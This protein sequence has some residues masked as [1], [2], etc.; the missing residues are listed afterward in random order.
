MKGM[1]A[2]LAG[3]AIIAQL[4]P[5]AEALGQCKALGK[6]LAGS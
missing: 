2:L 6:Q 3:E 4:E 1:G 5:S